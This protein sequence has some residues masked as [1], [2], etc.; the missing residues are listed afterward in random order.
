MTMSSWKGNLA[1]TCT[2][3]ECHVKRKAEIGVMLLQ[4]KER[5]RLP[6]NC[7]KLEEEAWDRVSLTARR[8]TQAWQHLDF[9]LL[10][11][12]PGRP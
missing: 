9:R 6:A 2:Q 10:A 4:A 7:Q 12:R 3:G 11:S 5:Q 1:Q 8:G